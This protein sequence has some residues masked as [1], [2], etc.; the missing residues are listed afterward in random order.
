M[1][2][3]DPTEIERF[4]KNANAFNKTSVIFKTIGA[5]FYLYDFIWVINKGFSNISKK[6]KINQKIK[7]T[8]YEI[9]FQD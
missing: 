9:E 8:K 1:N 3:S 7:S 6:N 2:S 4:Y 5:S